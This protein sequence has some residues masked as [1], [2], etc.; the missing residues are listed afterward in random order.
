M[1]HWIAVVGIVALSTAGAATQPKRPE[2][3]VTATAVTPSVAAGG[4][5][6]LSLAVTLPSN[7]HVQSNKPSDP[8]FI[9]TV[10]TVEPPAGFTVQDVVYPKSELLKQEGLAEPLHVF[11]SQFTIEVRLKAAATVAPGTLAVPARLRYQACDAT[12][13]YP[14]AR[15]A[16][17][18]TLRVEARQ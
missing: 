1:K 6:R 11:G 4:E 3:T 14:P 13:C 16:A 8:F 2:A 9:A 17:S 15:A 12:T 10:L 5:A 18:W 7:V